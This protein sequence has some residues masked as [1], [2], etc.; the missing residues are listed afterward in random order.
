M[1]SERG[2]EGGHVFS[3]LDSSKLRSALSI[4]AATQRLT[5]LPSRHRF[6]L[7]LV[8]RAME[9]IDSMALVL[10]QNDEWLVGRYLSAESLAL[11]LD[12]QADDGTEV[13]ELEAA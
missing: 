6:T 11:V 2:D 4:P 5:I 7:R 1:T 8:E 13:P 10:E 12:G 9:I 3:A